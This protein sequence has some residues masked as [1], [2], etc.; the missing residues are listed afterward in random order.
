MRRIHL[1][2]FV[3][4]FA[5]SAKVSMA[6]QGTS[7]FQINYAPTLPL[8]EVTDF[9]GSFS[10]RG[11]SADY[12]Y[13]IKKHFS[14]G[15]GTGVST[16]YEN[17]P[18]IASEQI[19]ENGKIVTITGKRFNY[20]NSI[21]FLATGTYFL[22]PEGQIQPYLGLGIGG[23]YVMKW[24]ELGMYSLR[25]NNFVFGLAP[26]A[27]VQMPL[28]YGVSMNLGAQYNAT[29]GESPF[30]SLDFRVGLAWKF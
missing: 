10:F 16:Y 8:G 4:F 15:F 5:L 20:T 6:Q 19:V 13:R 22:E 30:S 2:I 29:F 12:S 1:F 7:E 14:V 23:Y 25:D 28:S 11:F 18:G 9:T 27:G 24:A 21:P 3:L 26:R 17:V